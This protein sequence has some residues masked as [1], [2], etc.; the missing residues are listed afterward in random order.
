MQVN[1]SLASLDISD[2]RFAGND[3]AVIL[4]SLKVLAGWLAGW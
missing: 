1:R 3:T 4:N 2:N